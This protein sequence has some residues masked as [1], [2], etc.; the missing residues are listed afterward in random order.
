VQSRANTEA[1]AAREL[2]ESATSPV[3]DEQ[4]L[5][6]DLHV[7]T[8]FSAD[9]FMM[10]M[11]ILQGEGAHP[12]AD[13]CDYA[14]YCSG[15]DFWSINDHAESITP[16]RWQETQD[17]IRQC[18]AIA[19]DPQNPDMVSFLGWEWT[20]IGD[21]PENH[22][23]HKNVVL[24]DTEA[25]KVPRRPV[26]SGSFAS[27][28]MRQNVRLSQRVLL[29]LADFPNR[30]YYLNMM[31]FL[32]ELRDTPLCEEGVDSRKLPDSCSEGAETP[33]SCSRSSTSGLPGAGDS[34]RNDLG[35]YTPRLGVGHSS[36]R[37]SRSER[38]R[39]IE[40][41][42]G[43]QPRIPRSRSDVRRGRQ[44][45]L[46]RTAGRLRAVLLAGGRDHPRSLRRLEFRGVRAACRDGARQLRR[47]RRARSPDHTR[48]D[49][50]R[51][52]ELR[53]LSRLLPARLQLPPE[54]QRPV[55]H[56]T[57]ERGSDVRRSGRT[58]S[59]WHFG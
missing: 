5:F 27:Q 19:G 57:L 35:I 1:K 59:V 3:P 23:G 18:N 15:L 41:P 43:T 25:D 31:K 30:Q 32:S 10:G 17:A 45:R 37:S 12:I 6:G 55:H 7:H 50:R 47:R 49:G 21:T 38:Q 16:A 54:E 58:R 2:A 52:G 28:A 39:L 34:A 51:L 20:Q 36:T 13:A 11:P 33:G 24:R 42:S 46:P 9:A 56:G 29:P 26:H 22:Y 4:I 14:R 53:Q 48:R 40:V 44:R 8:T